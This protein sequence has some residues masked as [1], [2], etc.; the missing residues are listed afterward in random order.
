MKI[1]STTFLSNLLLFSLGT[2]T[3]ASQPNTLRCEI[4]GFLPSHTSCAV[5]TT[6]VDEGDIFTRYLAIST[7]SAQ[8]YCA[9]PTPLS[10]LL[11]LSINLLFILL[12]NPFFCGVYGVVYT[13]YRTDQIIF[14]RIHHH[15]QFL[16]P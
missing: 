15:C 14:H 13:S 4:K 3:N 12:E 2:C 9:S 8:N 16:A 7:S 6:S 10:M 1:H 11:S 5:L